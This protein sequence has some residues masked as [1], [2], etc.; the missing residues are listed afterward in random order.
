MNDNRHENIRPLFLSHR[1]TSKK[2]RFGRKF[3]ML[4]TFMRT[5]TAEIPLDE[6][7]RLAENAIKEDKAEELFE[8]I[9]DYLRNNHLWLRTETEVHQE[10]LESYLLGSYLMWEEFAKEKGDHKEKGKVNEG[11]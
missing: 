11:Y 1:S 8:A 9:S 10:A 3:S 7:R 6:W 5:P 2:D 4:L